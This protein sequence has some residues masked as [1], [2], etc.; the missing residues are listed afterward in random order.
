MLSLI[1]ALAVSA[2]PPQA[3]QE[4]IAIKPAIAGNAYLIVN[5]RDRPLGREY[6]RTGNVFR[7]APGFL[8]PNEPSPEIP[9]VVEIRPRAR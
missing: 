3:P 9:E 8:H 2:E 7:I 6:V 4:L 1:L 5:L